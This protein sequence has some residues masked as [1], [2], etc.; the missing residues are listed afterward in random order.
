[1]QQVLVAAAFTI[2]VCVCYSQAQKSKDVQS[3]TNQ[4]LEANRQWLMAYENCDVKG[5]ERLTAPDFVL[6]N[7]IGGL[8]PRSEFLTN[9]ECDS[10]GLKPLVPELDEIRVLL[11]GEGA[12][13]TCRSRSKEGDAGLRYTNVFVKRQGKWLVVSCQLTNILSVAAP[14]V[15]PVPPPGATPIK[16]S[17]K[18]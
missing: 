4:V 17:R 10:D 1:V 15:I 12:V 6:S 8:E 5:I 2:F 13:V 14:V 11:F 7:F 16:E 9:I 3:Q 18:P